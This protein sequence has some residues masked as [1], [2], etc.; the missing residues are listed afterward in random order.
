[1]A[2]AR[3]ALDGPRPQLPLEVLETAA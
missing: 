1:M 2:A 3:A